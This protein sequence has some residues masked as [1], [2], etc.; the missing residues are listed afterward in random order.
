MKYV[1]SKS[2]HAKEVNNTLV[3]D[4]GSKRGVEHL[5]YIKDVSN[6]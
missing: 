1:G 5:F 2:R 6:S 3:K 4:T